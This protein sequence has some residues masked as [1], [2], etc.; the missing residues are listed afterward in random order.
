MSAA[1]EHLFKVLLIGDSSVGKSCLLLRFVD[2]TYT[3][4]Y[5][6]TI[7]ADYKIKDLECEGARVRLQVWD[8]AGQERFRTITS[9][10]YRGSH[11]I[12]VVYDVTN[13]ESFENI[14]SWLQEVNR[15]AA[16]NVTVMLV[17]N[18]TDLEAGG[19]RRVSTAEGQQLADEEG[20]AFVETSAKVGTRV[21]ESFNDM[22]REIKSKT[23]ATK[24]PGGVNITRPTR[25]ANKKRCNI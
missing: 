17:G 19:E 7:G 4:E 13:A 15:Y 11:G 20:I 18:K 14:K 23:T 8:T 5:I 24:G 6:S 1:F 21:D 16:E 12:M 2:N 25:S 22:A 9:S 3:D 10:F